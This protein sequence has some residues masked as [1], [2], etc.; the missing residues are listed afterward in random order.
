[1]AGSTG[2]VWQLLALASGRPFLRQPSACYESI[3]STDVGANEIAM[4]MLPRLAAR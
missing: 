1:M 3:A 4:E 2:Q